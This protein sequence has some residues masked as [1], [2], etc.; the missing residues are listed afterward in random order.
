MPSL[1]IKRISFFKYAAKATVQITGVSNINYEHFIRGIYSGK[2]PISLVI[3]VGPV[4]NV[5]L[6]TIGTG[7]RIKAAQT[8]LSN[9]QTITGLLAGTKFSDKKIDQQIEF[10]GHY[11]IVNM[12]GVPHIGFKGQASELIRGLTSTS[13]N[14]LIILNAH[15][16]SLAKN[17]E[18]DTRDR[19]LLNDAGFMVSYAFFLSETDSDQLASKVQIL[20]SLLGSVYDSEHSETKVQIE[21]DKK[22]IK[23]LQKLLWGE[24]HYA[25]ILTTRELEAIFQIPETYSTES[26]QE[27]DFHVPI[28]S[29]AQISN[30]IPIGTVI[31]N[32]GEK[33][34]P[35]YLDPESIFQHIAIWG[36]TGYGKS[37]LIKNLI[38]NLHNGYGM[39]TLNFDLHNEYRAIVPAL[40]GDLGEDILIFNPFIKTFALNPLEIPSEV[41]GKERDIITVEVAENFISLLIQMW[42]LGEVQEQRCRTHL[43]ELYE[44]SSNPTISQLIGLLENDKLTKIKK[45]EDNLPSKMGKFVFGFYGEMFNKSHTTLPF[46][47]IANATTIFELG[48]LP[49]ELRTFFV[50]VFL[51]QWWNFRRVRKPDELSPHVLMLDEFHHYDNMAIPRKI[52]SEGRKY[53]EGVIC[54]HQGPFQITDQTLLGELVRNTVT[55]IVFKTLYQKDMEIILASLGLQDRTMAEHL[56]RLEL[57]EAIVTLRDV[58]QPFKIITNP[59]IEMQN[60][61]TNEQVRELCDALLEDQHQSDN[62]ITIIPAEQR[63]ADMDLEEKQFL[64]LLHETPHSSAADIISQMRIM[65]SK[66]WNI[67]N[68]LLNKGLLTE[69]TVRI[70]RG[71]PR[72]ILKLTDNGYSLLG[73]EKEGLPAHYGKEEHV[74]VITEI[75]D[76]L[77]KDGWEVSI[78]NGADIR[79]QKKDIRVAV[80]VETCKAFNEEQIVKNISRNLKW[81]DEVVIVSPNNQTKTRIGKL[82]KDQGFEKVTLL[83]YDQIK[84]SVLS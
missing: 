37:T 76:I 49:I 65:R 70:G 43:Y 79:A 33:L 39:H 31:G 9:M 73:V 14:V 10:R 41:T 22:A 44:L 36:T 63:D 60:R 82:V 24:L 5:F 66:G 17:E 1:E 6:S 12:I 78:E 54:S 40:Q 4:S 28:F 46:D 25:T 42:T 45:D 23:A 21:T 69:E 71:R 77:N 32:F 27:P 61:I 64:Q 57:G 50:T 13:S 74:Q 7:S 59:F 81:A 19:Y 35:A 67:K 29:E 53:K 62:V 26:I 56:S 52:L 83:T 8:A 68:N 15:P 38:V 20:I 2:T 55:K 51:S 30:G 11:A 34:H 3:R 18:S 48:E 72:I 75:A 84:S 58:N 16:V 47:K 80:E